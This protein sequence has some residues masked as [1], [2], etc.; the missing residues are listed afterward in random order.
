MAKVAA[1]AGDEDYFARLFQVSQI[2]K[3]PI[4]RMQ[5]AADPLQELNVEAPFDDQ[6]Q[7]DGRAGSIDNW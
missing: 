4:I 3:L 7:T 2:G 5:Y 6:D 1:A